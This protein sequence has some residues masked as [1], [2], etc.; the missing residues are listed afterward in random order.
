[1]FV[2]KEFVV[3][4]FSENIVQ[5]LLD[6]QSEC[7]ENGALKFVENVLPIFVQENVGGVAQQFV[8]VVQIAEM[9]PHSVPKTNTTVVMI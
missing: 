2:G 9:G 3:G 5:H 7:L 6:D 1:M 8:A 4:H